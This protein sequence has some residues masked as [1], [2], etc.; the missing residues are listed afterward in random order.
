[1]PMVSENTFG[2]IPPTEQESELAR[3]SSRLLAPF[4]NENDEDLHLLVDGAKEA[5]AVPQSAFRL[6]VEILAEMAKGNAITIIPVHAELTTQQAADVI[7]VSRPFLVRLLEEKKIKFHKVGTHRRIRY[8]DLIDY[9]RQ[10]DEERQKTLN[11]LAKE[12]QDLD[13]GY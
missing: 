10:V 1:M 7:N 8:S 4:L 11:E 5:V 13:M 12:A 2:P 3:E 6:L 9:K